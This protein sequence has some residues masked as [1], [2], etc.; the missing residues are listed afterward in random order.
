MNNTD[1]IER[2]IGR[3]EGIVKTGFDEINKRLDRMNGT[4]KDHDGKINQLET[5]RDNYEG[6][7]KQVGKMASIFGA[8][9][10]GFVSAVIWIVTKFFSN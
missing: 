10:G 2:S 8:I 5:F 9:V 6:Q 1:N 3:L 7:E 4:I